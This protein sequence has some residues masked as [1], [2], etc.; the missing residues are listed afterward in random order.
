VH[1]GFVHQHEESLAAVAQQP[2]GAVLGIG[3]G[4]R[5]RAG[6]HTGIGLDYVFR[7]RHN[8]DFSVG[9]EVTFT[10]FDPQYSVGPDFFIVADANIAAHF[11]L[12]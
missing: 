5:H 11:R 3:V 4:I 6:L 2:F 10:W 1:I 7:R 8:Y 12:F 9:G